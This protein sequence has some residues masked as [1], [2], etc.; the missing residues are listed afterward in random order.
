MQLPNLYS[1]R[2]KP[3]GKNP[4]RSS[5][6]VSRTPLPISQFT[7]AFKLS[8]CREKKMYCKKLFSIKA[9]FQFFN[10]FNFLA[11]FFVMPKNLLF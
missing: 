10:K 8:P 2:G 7:S 1:M 6:K 4:A 5:E 3:D 9:A 11:I